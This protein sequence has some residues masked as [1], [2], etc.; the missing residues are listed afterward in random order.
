VYARFAR[1]F[2]HA[3]GKDAMYFKIKGSFFSE[4][5]LNGAYPVTV[6][7]VYSDKG[8]G[9]WSLRYDAVDDPGKTALSVTNTNSG[10][11]KEKVVTLTDA[12]FGKRGSHGADL[13]LVNT[14]AEDCIFHIVELTRPK[15]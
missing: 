6:R 10:A 5:P 15:Q 8:G 11:W 2:D 4:K 9:R 14:G 7:V 13:V 3:T 1:G 12:Y